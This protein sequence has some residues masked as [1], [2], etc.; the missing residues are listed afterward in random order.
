MDVLNVRVLIEQIIFAIVTRMFFI[1]CHAY[2]SIVFA[3]EEDAAN[4]KE[5]PFGILAVV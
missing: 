2:T 5:L 1:F 3:I 4:G